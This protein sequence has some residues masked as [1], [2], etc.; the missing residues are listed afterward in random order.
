MNS[1][2][3]SR[4]FRIKEILAKMFK[5]VKIIDDYLKKIRADILRIS[6]KDESYIIAIKHLS[7]NLV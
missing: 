5:W 4:N 2:A 7:S 1:D 3:Y 6:K